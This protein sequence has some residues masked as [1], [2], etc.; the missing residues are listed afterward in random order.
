M[1]F[2]LPRSREGRKERESE[3]EEARRVSKLTAVSVSLS[4]VAVDRLLFHFVTRE[5]FR[6]WLNLR[7][8]IAL[9]RCFPT[10]F[11]FTQ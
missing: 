5:Y 9:S 10:R 3:R 7:I 8:S 1:L 6:R 2:V 11:I 4:A